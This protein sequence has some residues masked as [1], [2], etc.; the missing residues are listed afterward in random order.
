[1]ADK[2]KRPPSPSKVIEENT[3][4]GGFSEPRG[5]RPLDVSDTLP[6]PPPPGKGGNHDSGKSD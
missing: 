2:N 1:M 4:R 6:P 3:Q 5:P